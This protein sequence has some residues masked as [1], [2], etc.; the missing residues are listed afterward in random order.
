MLIGAGRYARLGS[1]AG[2]RPWRSMIS[3]TFVR[4][5]GPPAAALITSALSRKNCG[6][7]AAGVTAHS[8]LASVIPLLS[9]L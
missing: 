4:S 5:G 3:A 6:H 2:V 9:N 7:S 1:A 8:T